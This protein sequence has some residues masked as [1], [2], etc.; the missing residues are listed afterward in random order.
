M[1]VFPKKSCICDAPADSGTRLGRPSRCERADKERRT[2]RSRRRGPGKASTTISRATNRE[3]QASHGRSSFHFRL[4][5]VRCAFT[6]SL[7]VMVQDQKV[8]SD[9]VWWSS[10]ECK[11]RPKWTKLSLTRPF[12]FGYFGAYVLRHLTAR[13]SANRATPLGL[14]TSR[15]RCPTPSRAPSR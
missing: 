3:K 4:T 12:Q 2:P 13:V 7:A 10:N 15:D 14:A 8:R 1:E 11:Q 5:L 6:P 9:L